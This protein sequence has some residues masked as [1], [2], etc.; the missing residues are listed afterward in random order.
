MRAVSPSHSA[1]RSSDAL[2]TC[3]TPSCYLRDLEGVR[4]VVHLR[5]LGGQRGDAGGEEKAEDKAE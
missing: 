5:G 4:R 1:G 2:F 3:Y